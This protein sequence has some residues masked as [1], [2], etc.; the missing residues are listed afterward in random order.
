[1]AVLREAGGHVVV[2]QVGLGVLAVDL[3]PAVVEPAVGVLAVLFSQIHDGGVARGHLVIH[4]IQQAL[5]N[6]GR[7]GE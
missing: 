1:M 7:L 2:G 5:V 6:A 3:V 4:G